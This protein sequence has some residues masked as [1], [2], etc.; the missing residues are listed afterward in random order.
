VT[1]PSFKPV[2]LET[3]EVQ[4][5]GKDGNVYGV[6]GALDRAARKAAWPQETIEAMKH[7]CFNE[8]KDYDE[9]IQMALQNFEVL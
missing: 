3:P 8:A 1:I 2:D 4:L 7:W 9:I 5:S 6:I